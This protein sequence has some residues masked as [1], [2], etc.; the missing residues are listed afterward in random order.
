MKLQKSGKFNRREF[1][2]RKATKENFGDSLG[3]C[4]EAILD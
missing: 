2:E 1:I 4:G 3:S